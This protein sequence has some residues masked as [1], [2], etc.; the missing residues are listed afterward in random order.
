MSIEEQSHQL[1]SSIIEHCRA[2]APIPFEEVYFPVGTGPLIYSNENKEFYDLTGDCGL[3][4]YGHPLMIKHNLIRTLSGNAPT[5]SSLVKRQA[6]SLLSEFCLKRVYLSYPVSGAPEYMFGRSL[7][8]DLKGLMVKNPVINIVKAFSFPLAIST[9]KQP[10]HGDSQEVLKVLTFLKEGQFFGETG[11]IKN[12]ESQLKSA[13]EELSIVKNIN[14]LIVDLHHHPK[15]DKILL[16]KKST[17]LIFPL[18]F[19][20]KI[21]TSIKRELT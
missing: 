2:G 21:L 5:N 8:S 13:F 17:S 15:S 9:K 12:R 7:N 1:F 16:N 3:L 4:G 19:N 14:G 18:S 11:L 6:E 10:Y 20:D